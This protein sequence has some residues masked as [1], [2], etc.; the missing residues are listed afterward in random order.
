MNSER[1][2]KRA[3]RGL[4]GQHRQDTQAELRGA[5]ED[6]IYRYSL[7]GLA[8]ADAE[9]AALRDLGDPA[10]IA[11]ELRVVHTLTPAL[12]FALLTGVTVLLSFQAAAKNY[13]INAAP[14]PLEVR[15]QSCSMELNGVYTHSEGR[16]EFVE[17]QIKMH[18]SRA[19]AEAACLKD[20]PNPNRF[21]RVADLN[22][23]L[24]GAGF[25]VF[26]DDLLPGRVAVD[27]GG[28]GNWTTL[29]DA[30]TYS[31]GKV[32]D[33]PYADAYIL[34]SNLR[35][36][37]TVP[38]QLKGTRNPTLI[39]GSM[40]AQLGTEPRPV[41][42]ID[43][44]GGL[45]A[46]DLERLLRQQHQTQLHFSGVAWTDW[47]N[48]GNP[49]AVAERGEALYGVLSSSPGCGCADDQNQDSFLTLSLHQ[50]QQGQIKLPLNPLNRVN[51]VQELAQARARGHGAYLLYRVDASDL[52]NVKFAVVP[53]VPQVWK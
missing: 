29:V 24:K 3:T 38:L 13:V 43:L 12:K 50:A 37:S 23:A 4:Y 53:K 36:Q 35:L 25:K 31:S 17:Q 14:A 5:I 6:K 33:E 15:Q 30:G 11:Q 19:R 1:Y 9:Q 41:Q 8:P 48:V 18:G 51:N 16:R 34:L 42:G 40:K 32:N 7:L 49:L 39:I 27:F 44:L 52:R 45:V 26:E 10:A 21:I 2:L 46:Q 47:S 28:N 20:L 22:A